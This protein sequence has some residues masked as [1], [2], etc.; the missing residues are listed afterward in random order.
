MLAQHRLEAG[1][2]SLASPD[3]TIPKQKNDGKGKAIMF[4]DV[5]KSMLLHERL[6]D[7]KARIIIDQLLEM[8]AKAVQ[9]HKGRVVKTI[10][11][12]LLAV[13]PSADAAARAAR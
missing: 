3:V 13:L 7:E 4:A 8:A 11:D 2:A 10:G 1:I 5:S 6:G 12:E 9:Q